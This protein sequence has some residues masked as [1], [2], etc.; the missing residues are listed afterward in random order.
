MAIDGELSNC[1]VLA[2]DD[3]P[4]QLYTLVELLESAGFSVI[5]SPN[6]QA[7][8]SAAARDRPDLILMDV[9]MPVLDGLEA[10]RQLKAD[11]ALKAIPVVLLTSQDSPEDIRHGLE[12]GANDYISKPFKRIELLGRIKAALKNGE[13][14][15][16]LLRLRAASR[17]GGDPL[18]ANSSKMNE[19]LRLVERAERSEIPILVTGETGTG[20]ELLARRI[21]SRSKRSTRPFYA[22]NCAL[23]QQDLLRS[24]LFGHVKG[25]FTGA[26]SDRK[27]LF[28]SSNGGTLLLDEIGEMELDLQA[29]LLRVLEDGSFQPL[30]TA[31]VESCDVRIIAATH[32]NLEEMVSA[33]LFREDLFYRIN[34]MEIALPPLRDRREDIKALAEHFLERAKSEFQ[35][36][37]PRELSQEILEL[38]VSYDWPG[39][40]RQ[41]KNEIFRLVALCDDEEF[42][43]VSSLSRKVGAG[44][45]QPDLDQKERDRLMVAGESTAMVTLKEAVGSLESRLIKEALSKCSGNK[46]EAARMLG[47]SRSSLIA[48]I[49]GYS[50]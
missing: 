39:N 6:G 31:R 50:L 26:V 16:E 18:V 33:G 17:G 20:K 29:Q 44:K 12:V 8:L 5:Q 1:K 23:F 3:D 27:G 11:S 19:V 35:S 38:L 37:S 7:A 48:K 9:K 25:A 40:I 15:Q 2:V 22:V 34:M 32:R 28:A 45:V 24:E 21:H 41:L 43:P 47:I 30:G 49:K 42:I 13:L 46:S 36:T 4:E 14:Y 10:T